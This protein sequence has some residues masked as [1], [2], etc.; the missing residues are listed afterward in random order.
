MQTD[1]GFLKEE[2]MG[3]AENPTTYI[4]R[5]LRHWKEELERD[6]EQDKVLTALFRTAIVEAMP[7]TVKAKLEDVVG[8][9]SKTHK[10]FRD[11]VVHA[12]EQHRKQEL[13]IKN[14]EKELQRKLTQLQLEELINKKKKVRQYKKKTNQQ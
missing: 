13:K 11:H 9:N 8:L 7:L 3:E 6:P 1:P 12:V 2:P 10:E 14:Q 4:Q 5:Q